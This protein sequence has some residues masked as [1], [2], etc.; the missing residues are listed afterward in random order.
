MVYRPLPEEE[1][2]VKL[3]AELPRHFVLMF[4]TS[5][6]V[7]P[8]EPQESPPKISASS[9]YIRKVHSLPAMLTTSLALVCVQLAGQLANGRTAAFLPVLVLRVGTEFSECARW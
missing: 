9:H 8:S 3:S 1:A 2:G 5:R 7:Q 4:A 6:I